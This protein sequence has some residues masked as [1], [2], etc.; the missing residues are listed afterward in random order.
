MALDGILDCIFDG[1]FN[2]IF[3]GRT[4]LWNPEHGLIIIK[5]FT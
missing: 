2:G 4:Y 1:I 5:T 3:N